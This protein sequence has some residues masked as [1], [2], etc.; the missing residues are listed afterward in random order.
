MKKILLSKTDSSATGQIDIFRQSREGRHTSPAS[1]FHVAHAAPANR[2]I[3]CTV[4][5]I[6]AARGFCARC[7]TSTRTSV[8]CA[9][10]EQ[11]SNVFTFFAVCTIQYY[12]YG[13]FFQD[14]GIQSTKKVVPQLMGT[15]YVHRCVHTETEVVY[16]NYYH[17]FLFYHLFSH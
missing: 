9:A 10:G 15:L 4:L 3:L 1:H 5:E 7:I 17:R 14:E 2:G 11:G 16:Y 13:N 8:G 6:Q 12:E